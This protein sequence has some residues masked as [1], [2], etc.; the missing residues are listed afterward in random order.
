MKNVRIIAMLVLLLSGSGIS[1]AYPSG[2]NLV[3]LE[4]ENISQLSEDLQELSSSHL[5]TSVDLFNKRLSFSSTPFASIENSQ[6]ISRAKGYFSTS[7]SIEPGLGLA[8][9]IFPFHSFL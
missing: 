3:P 9:I 7:T 2:I 1:F 4:K 8:D 5:V 6:E